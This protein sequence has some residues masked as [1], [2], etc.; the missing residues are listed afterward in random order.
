MAPSH[1]PAAPSFLEGCSWS[2]SGDRQESL[3][4]VSNPCMKKAHIGCM[5]WLDLQH[6]SLSHAGTE[7]NALQTLT[8]SQA[9]FRHTGSDFQR[10]APK[11]YFEDLF[12]GQELFLMR[13][14]LIYVCPLFRQHCV[15]GTEWWEKNPNLHMFTNKYVHLKVQF[16]RAVLKMCTYNRNKTFF[17]AKSSKH[18]IYFQKIKAK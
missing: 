16:H 10:Q 11:S 13:T 8:W 2:S 6:T 1:W 15:G 17:F 12:A 18:K 14:D 4:G 9:Q 5:Y 7:V 3:Q